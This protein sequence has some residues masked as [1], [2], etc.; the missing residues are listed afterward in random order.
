MESNTPVVVAPLYHLLVIAAIL[1][2]NLVIN[3]LS[4]WSRWREQ[5]RIYKAQAKIID[6]L[7]S[8]QSQSGSN[9]AELG[10]L[11]EAVRAAGNRVAVVNND[12]HSLF[13]RLETGFEVVREPAPEVEEDAAA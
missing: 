2:V 4:G 10:L 1:A 6:L 5:S 11:G 9:S 8:L 13:T 7:L 3:L 12:L